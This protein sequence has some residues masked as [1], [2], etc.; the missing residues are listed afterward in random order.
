MKLEKRIKKLEKRFMRKN[1]DGTWVAF[2]REDDTV[3]L[4]HIKHED[5]ELSNSDA[6][7]AFINEHGLYG[8]KILVVD[9][10]KE[11]EKDLS[12]KIFD[13]LMEHTEKW[14]CFLLTVYVIYW[15]FFL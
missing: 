11:M 15:W 3:K 8:K 4:S 1:I 2:I 10:A 7:H 12:D 9:I 5:V 6:L 14:I 13:H